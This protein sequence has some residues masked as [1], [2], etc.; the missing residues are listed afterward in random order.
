MT[1]WTLVHKLG[2]DQPKTMKELLDIATRHTSCEEEIG[3]VFVQGDGK[4]V[5]DSCREALAKATGKGGKNGAK[6]SKERQKRR[7]KQ[8]AVTTIGTTMKT[9]KWMAPM[10][11][12]S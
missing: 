6:G 9:R 7:P 12:M 5:L 4:T 8:V 2:R 10:S 11:S 3:T 1:Y